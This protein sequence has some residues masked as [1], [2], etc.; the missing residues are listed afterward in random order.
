MAVNPV[1]IGT[2]SRGI[3]SEP[4]AQGL[5]VRTGTARNSALG[6]GID[7]DMGIGE[8]GGRDGGAGHG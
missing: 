2:V 5:A 8:N 3:D 7:I 6:V 1:Q 4:R